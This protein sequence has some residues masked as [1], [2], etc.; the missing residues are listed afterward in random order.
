M[1]QASTSSAEPAVLPAEVS[2]D[3]EQ[4]R[5]RAMRVDV[6][7][8]QQAMKVVL[9]T[10]QE[11][12][13]WQQRAAWLLA[14]AE[15]LK[16]SGGHDPSIAEE[17][18]ALMSAV[19]TRREHLMSAVRSL[20]DDVAQSSRLEDTAR[21]LDSVAGVLTKALGLMKHRRIGRR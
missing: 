21:A 6:R 17:A 13:P 8:S 7:I 9:P 4:N 18:E 3:T 15:R 20:P 2:A 10:N 12:G 19:E 5:Q 1:K 14:L 11:I 16:A